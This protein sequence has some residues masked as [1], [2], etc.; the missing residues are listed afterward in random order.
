MRFFTFSTGKT[1][2][3]REISDQQKQILRKLE[4]IMATQKEL[5]S[6]LDSLATAVSDAATR[7]SNDLKVLQDKIAA[8][9]A[10]ADL[11]PEVARIAGMTDAIAAIDPAAATPIAPVT[12]TTTAP[13]TP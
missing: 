2:P 11:A 6:A 5:D 12:S 1:E 13:P 4:I 9:P 7:V 10:A 3:L 8:I